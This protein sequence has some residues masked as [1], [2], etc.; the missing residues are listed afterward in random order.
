[1]EIVLY[2][3]A[4]R[5]KSSFLYHNLKVKYVP[6]PLFVLSTTLLFHMNTKVWT[7]TFLS[8]KT[9]IISLLQMQKLSFQQYNIEFFKITLRFFLYYLLFFCVSIGL[10]LSVLKWNV[11]SKT[12]LQNYLNKP[13]KAFWRGLGFIITKHSVSQENL[14]DLVTPMNNSL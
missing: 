7:F 12:V 14:L 13:L 11:L 6:L 2:K 1:M 8:L 5:A 9:Y 10:S 4:T 3:L